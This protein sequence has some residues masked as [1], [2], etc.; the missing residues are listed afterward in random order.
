M[1]LHR[2]RKLLSSQ[3]GN[4]SS[5]S[6]SISRSRWAKYAIGSA[7]TALSGIGC[8]ITTAE[9][10]IHYSGPIRQ[11]VDATMTRSTSEAFF[12][13]TEGASLVFIH[14]RASNN[15]GAAFVDLRGAQTDLVRGTGDTASKLYA[16]DNISGGPFIAEGPIFIIFQDDRANPWSRRGRGFVGFQFNTGHGVQYGWARL[17]LRGAPDNS[18]K[19]IDYAWADPGESIIAG[20]TSET[21]RAAAGAVPPSDSL[22]LLALGGRGLEAWRGQRP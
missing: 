16:G 12:P 3:R 11:A 7:A 20:Q 21:G 4:D 1:K 9:A 17:L 5:R 15:K 22:G 18:F 13:L 2:E 8:S 6:A 19:V 10:E 14:G